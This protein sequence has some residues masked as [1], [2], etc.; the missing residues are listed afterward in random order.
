M[1]RP[2]ALANNNSQPWAR[3]V[4]TRGALICSEVLGRKDGSTKRFFPTESRSGFVWQT[5]F[6]RFMP[7]FN[8]GIVPPEKRQ[9][10]PRKKERMVIP[11][12]IFPDK[13]SGAFAVNLRGC[14]RIC[15]KNYIRPQGF[16]TFFKVGDSQN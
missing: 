6:S 14:N 1:L 10:G 11:S 4:D 12:S 2:G 13:I 3:F 15:I 7:M 9:K 16:A 5:P 8:V